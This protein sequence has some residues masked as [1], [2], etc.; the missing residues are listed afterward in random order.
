MIRNLGT[1]AWDQLARTSTKTERN[2]LLY[3]YMG[4]FH[5]H[6]TPADA[7]KPYFIMSSTSH[8][9]LNSGQNKFIAIWYYINIIQQV[10][11]LKLFLLMAVFQLIMN[12]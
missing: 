11:F 5:I 7:D 3:D 6:T 10:Y 1:K 4:I 9:A 8:N 12:N 2:N